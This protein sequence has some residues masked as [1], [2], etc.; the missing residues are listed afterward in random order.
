MSSPLSLRTPD[1]GAGTQTG[2]AT[3]TTAYQAAETNDY[4][5]VQYLIAWGIVFL[6]LALLNRTRWGHALIYYALILALA[7]LLLVNYQAI[8]S[9]I[10]P[11]SG[12]QGGEEQGPNPIPES[13]VAH[14][15]AAT[16]N[17]AVLP[18][19]AVPTTRAPGFATA[20]GGVLSGGRYG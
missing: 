1:G 12:I 18:S 10:A 13:P 9:L 6:I 19:A 14:P 3:T 4:S 11:A 20:S 2:N 15:G 7:V 17:L 5:V 8:T 16:P